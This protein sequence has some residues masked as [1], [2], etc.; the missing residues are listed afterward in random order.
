MFNDPRSVR[1]IARQVLA[2]VLIAC[3]GQVTAEATPEWGER[4]PRLVL[5][6]GLSGQACMGTPMEKQTVLIPS[7]C[8]EPGWTEGASVGSLERDYALVPARGAV[9]QAGLRSSMVARRRHAIGERVWIQ[10]TSRWDAAR[11]EAVTGSGYWL[12]SE[13]ATFCPGDSGA[14]AWAVEDASPVWMAMVVSGEGRQGC[15]ARSTAVSSQSIDWP[16]AR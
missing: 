2:C 16:W 1:L 12:R 10:R 15:S 5:A 8:A 4:L 9:G 14:A 13:G 11:I 7:H 6:G 3:G